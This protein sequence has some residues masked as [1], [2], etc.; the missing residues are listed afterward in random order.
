MAVEEGKA[1]G[2]FSGRISLRGKKEGGKGGRE[3][4]FCHA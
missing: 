1:G 3:Q 4:T 2:S